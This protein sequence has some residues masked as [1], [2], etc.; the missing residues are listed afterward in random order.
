MTLSDDI[1][2]LKDLVMALLAKVEALESENA[3]LRVENADLRSRLNLNSKNSHK[4]PSSDGLSKKPGLPKEPPKKSGG[5]F[6]HKGKTLKMVDTPDIVLVYHVPS[7]PCCS[8]VFSPADV[9]EVVQKRQV[10]DIP[11]PIMEVTEHQLGV[12]VCCGRQHLG[13]FPPQVGQPVQ[14]GSRIKALSVLLNNDY[15]LPLEKIEQLMGD[16]W[17]CSFNQSTAVTANAGIYQVLEPI[18]AQIKAAILAS[19]VAHFDETGMRVEKSLHW[20]H[21]TSTSWFT[22]LFVHKKRGR[23]ALDSAHSLLKDFENRAVHD[24][25]ESYFG[26][27]QCQHALCGAHLLRELTH[28]MENGSK[29]AAQMRQF[30]LDLYRNSQKATLILADRQ[31]WEREFKHICQ[32]ADREEPPP[33]KGKK[34]KPKNSKGRNLLNR[35]TDHQHEWLAFAFVEDVPFSNNQAERDIRPLKTKQKVATS[36]QTFKGAQHYA[37]VQSFTSSLRKHSM[38]VFQNLIN[39]FDRKAINF[40]AG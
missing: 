14:Y 40:Q 32:M 19:P 5:Q 10:F 38:N 24:C 30:M 9:V 16:L 33:Q 2:V 4:P 7:C 37:L 35:L 27:K 26:Y 39:A 12:V 31:T 36:F 25:W 29:W 23:Q 6:G 18:E 22:Y 28:L 15:K 1:K 13:S 3:A 21:V 20:F 34:G 17:G 11:A 8:K